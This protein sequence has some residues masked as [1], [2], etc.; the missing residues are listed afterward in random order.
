M[1]KRLGPLQD[2]P[3]ATGQGLDFLQRG[4]GFSVKR[5]RAKEQELR[6]GENGGEGI[7]EIVA[8]L[9]KTILRDTGQ[10]TTER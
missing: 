3:H 5:T 1:P 2:L 10:R 8:E 4:D 6:F 7:G 9:P